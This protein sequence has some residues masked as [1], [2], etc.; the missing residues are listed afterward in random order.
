MEK[1][2]E[3]LFLVLE[4]MEFEPVTGTYLNYEENTW[5]TVNVLPNSPKISDLTKI[6]FF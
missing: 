2:I 6:D 5:S 1:K 4:M 3:K